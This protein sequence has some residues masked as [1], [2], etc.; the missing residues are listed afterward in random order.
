MGRLIIVRLVPETWWE[1]VGRT[2]TSREQRGKARVE[3]RDTRA[4]VL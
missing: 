2:Q 3:L 1:L 4:G